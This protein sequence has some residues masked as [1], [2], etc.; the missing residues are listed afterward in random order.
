M[1]A[2]RHLVNVKKST[3]IYRERDNE[4]IFNLK[5]FLRHKR[6]MINE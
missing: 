4:M 3:R 6:L 2:I 5:P 1:K